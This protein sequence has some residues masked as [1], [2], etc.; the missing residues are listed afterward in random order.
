MCSVSILQRLGSLLVDDDKK[1]RPQTLPSTPRSASLR[2]SSELDPVALHDIPEGA[3]SIDNASANAASA[4]R[5]PDAVGTFLRI[6]TINDVYKL[7]NYPSFK[8]AVNEAREHAKHIDCVV[9]SHLNGDFLAP[10]I[11]SALDGGRAMATA[12]DLAGVQYAC[13]GNHELDLGFAALGARVNELHSAT[14]INSNVPHESL[15]SLQKFATFQIGSRWCVLGGFLTED[16]SIYAPSLHPPID[17]VNE[18]ITATWEA[19]TTSLRQGGELKA[20][21]YPS[22]FLPMTHQLMKDDQE[23]ARIISSHPTLAPRTPIILA[24]HDHEPFE[25]A[26]EG[27]LIVKVGT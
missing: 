22:L 5:P 13:I 12:L 18:S 27:S 26:V 23:T 25:E 2:A 3:G 10:C 4:P 8:T 6:V 7:E 24:G 1:R 21:E 15:D 20:D 9:T 17:P 14:V 19:G 11:L 16:P